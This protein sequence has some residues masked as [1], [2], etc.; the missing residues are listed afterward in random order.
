M[1]NFGR[2][3]ALACVTAL[4]WGILAIG[5][6]LATYQIDAATIGWFRFAF[7]FVVLFAW[8]M[9][10]QPKA[11]LGVLRKPPWIILGA[12][13]GLVVNY[14]TF[15]WG[16]Q[17]TSPSLA[18]ILIQ[19]GPLCLIIAGVFIFKEPLNVA[20]SI[21][22]VAATLGFALFYYDQA[23]LV[24]APDVKK[25]SLWI[26]VGAISWAFCAGIQK[27]L[28]Q[29]FPSS[30]VNLLVY[31]YSLVMM[32]PLC[33]FADLLSLDF[34]GWLLLLF[35]GVNTLLAYGALSEA[36]VHAPANVVS[37]IITLNPLIT[38]AIMGLGKVAGVRWL[39]P[40]TIHWYGYCGALIAL[41]GASVVVLKRRGRYAD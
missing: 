17:L 21:G 22:L 2:G 1:P 11:T 28:V 41:F 3:V 8:M 31:G 18:Q 33:R 26:I 13:A 30:Q 6:K 7:S 38:L 27:H 19:V 24:N 29:K 39:P 5:L 12:C 40:E 25:G 20:Q 4:M 10:R 14:V 9:A 32:A 15:T 23:G 16:L 34:K 36:F 35:L 37:I